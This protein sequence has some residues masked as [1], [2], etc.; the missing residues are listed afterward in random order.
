MKNWYGIALLMVL[1]ACGGTM[2]EEQRKQMLEAKKEQAI[3]RVTDVQ[4]TEAAFELGR[5]VMQQLAENPSATDSLAKAMGVTVKWLVPGATDAPEIEKQI[6]DAYINSVLMGEAMQDNV[7][8]MGTDSLLYTKPL[9]E[10]K[11][12]GSVEIKGTWNVRISKKQLIRQL[13]K[14]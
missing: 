11:A 10:K 3:I 13:N 7:Q 8:K 14:K 1:T 5:S 6:I 4:I 2:T 12:D 9:V